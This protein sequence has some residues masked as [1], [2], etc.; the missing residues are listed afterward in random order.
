MVEI[1]FEIV[2]LFRGDF[3]SSWDINLEINYV[4][5]ELVQQPC[6][7]NEV[8]DQRT[9]F[10]GKFWTILKGQTFILQDFRVNWKRNPEK[11][12]LKTGNFKIFLIPIEFLWAE[13]CL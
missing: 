9:L 8:H 10:L 11:W 12:S 6:V 4:F 1:K 3:A 2:I 5:M 13:S 7:F